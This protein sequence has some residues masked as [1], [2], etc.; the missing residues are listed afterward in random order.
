[1]VHYRD[2][3]SRKLCLPSFAVFGNDDNI[4]KGLIGEGFRRRTAQFSRPAVEYGP[5]RFV[6]YGESDRIAVLIVRIRLE[7]II[8][9]NQ[10]FC[11]R[12]SAD[13]RRS[14]KHPDIKTICFTIVQPSCF[15]AVRHTDIEYVL[16]SVICC[17]CTLE[18]PCFTVEY[19]P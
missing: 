4:F 14:I 15:K 5:C 1:M 13:H 2:T 17:R 10:N 19:C 3:E 7:H 6:L 12:R 16:F 11:R 8:I 18:F 9:E